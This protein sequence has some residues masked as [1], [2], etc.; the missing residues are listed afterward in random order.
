M[1]IALWAITTASLASVTLSQTNGRLHKHFYAWLISFA[2][3]LRPITDA[4]SLRLDSLS[5]SIQNQYS[6]S[7]GNCDGHTFLWWN[8]GSS[9]LTLNKDYSNMTWFTYCSRARQISF[10]FIQGS[11]I[12]TGP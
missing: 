2:C 6:S 3:V 7:F 1:L 5:D 8:I 12:K 4:L 10:G 9:Q 11:R